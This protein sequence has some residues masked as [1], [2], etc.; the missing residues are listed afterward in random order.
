MLENFATVI[1][2]TRRIQELFERKRVP[3]RPR[4]TGELTCGTITV[5]LRQAT[6]GEEK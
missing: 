5:P 6:A 2:N 1:F 3:V 4:A